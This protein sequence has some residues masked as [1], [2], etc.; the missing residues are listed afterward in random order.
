[1]S[2]ILEK[3][4]KIEQLLLQSVTREK[5]SNNNY[6]KSKDVINLLQVSNSTLQNMRITQKIK[7]GRKLGGTWRYEKQEI[8]KNI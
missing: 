1:M 2:I 7:T 6:Y 4:N 8:D 5:S 3:I